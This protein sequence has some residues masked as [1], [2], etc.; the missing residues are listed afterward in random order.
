MDRGTPRDVEFDN[1]F[2]KEAREDWLNEFMRL[3]GHELKYIKQLTR[4]EMEAIVDDQEG[5]EFIDRKKT[6]K[7]LIREFHLFEMADGTPV[8]SQWRVGDWKTE[9]RSHTV[10]QEWKIDGMRCKDKKKSKK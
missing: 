1:M 9:W 7:E 3:S 5:L 10:D 8:V 6:G 4:E 2:V